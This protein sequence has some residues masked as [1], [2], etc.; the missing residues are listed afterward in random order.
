MQLIADELS[1]K[2]C[3]RDSIKYAPFLCSFLIVYMFIF[4]INVSRSMQ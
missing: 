2:I 4:S 3:G 1:M